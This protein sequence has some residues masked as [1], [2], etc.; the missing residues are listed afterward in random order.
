M[1]RCL[2]E[3]SLSTDDW[4]TVKQEVSAYSALGLTRTQRLGGF[5]ACKSSMSVLL[6][7]ILLHTSGENSCMCRN[8]SIDQRNE[9]S[10]AIDP[11]NRAQET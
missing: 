1:F 9:G 4:V 3:G 8:R 6:A 7:C 5:V 10:K 11:S 2:L